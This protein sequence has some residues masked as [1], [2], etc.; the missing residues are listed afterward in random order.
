MWVAV[1]ILYDECICLPCVSLW[2]WVFKN[3][4]RL[5]LCPCVW[6]GLCV[7][8]CVCEC[9]SVCVCSS[10]ELTVRSWPWPRFSSCCW[11][12]SRRL[13]W[14]LLSLLSCRTLSPGRDPLLSQLACCTYNTT[15]PS[16]SQ[17]EVKSDR[18]HSGQPH[19]GCHKGRSPLTENQREVFNKW[20]VMCHND[21][22]LKLS[23]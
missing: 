22:T 2:E 23:N 11:I 7:R 14:S 3:E 21:N 10:F 9:K 13:S 12:C 4:S 6:V 1:S 19:Q 15:Q 18:C 8:E 16:F 17:L 20:S 5:W